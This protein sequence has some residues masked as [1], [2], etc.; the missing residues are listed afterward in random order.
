MLKDYQGNVRFYGLYRGVVV[1]TD[2][3]KSLGR[4]KLQVPQ[5]LLNEV[6]DW[7]YGVAQPGVT[8]TTPD[9]G[10]GVFVMFEGGDPSFPV[11]LGTFES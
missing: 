7:A 4:L 6:T 1:A 3:P 9:I 2:D 10:S 5:V 11:W 8:R